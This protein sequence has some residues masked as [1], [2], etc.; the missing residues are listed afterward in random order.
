MKGY[1]D[2]K[3]FYVLFSQKVG[4]S[5]YYKHWVGLP[6]GNLYYPGTR[7]MLNSIRDIKKQTRAG[8]ESKVVPYSKPEE[9]CEVNVE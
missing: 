6:K 7:N 5:I 9:V 4:T 2:E 8:G 3:E 1:A